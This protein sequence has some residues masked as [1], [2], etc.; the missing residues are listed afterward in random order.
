MHH[1]RRLILKSAWFL[2]PVPGSVGAHAL[3][4]ANLGPTRRPIDTSGQVGSQVPI[5]FRIPQPTPS[6]SLALSGS[7][8]TISSSSAPLAFQGGLEC[9]IDVSCQPQIMLG[10]KPAPDTD[11]AGFPV[12]IHAVLPCCW[13]IKEDCMGPYNCNFTGAHGANERMPFASHA[14]RHVTEPVK[15]RWQYL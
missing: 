6:R 3:F 10:S 5:C 4:C 1:I 11:A 9:N 15:I 13:P 8:Y 2:D 12:Q 7:H 14:S